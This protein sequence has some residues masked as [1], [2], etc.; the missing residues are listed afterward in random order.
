M[1]ANRNRCGKCEQE[2]KRGKKNLSKRAKSK[3]R[4]LT[5]QTAFGMTDWVLS[6]TTDTRLPVLENDLV[7]H[8]VIFGLF[9]VHDV[10]T[11]YILFDAFDGLTG[12]LRENAV[13][14]GAHAENFFGVKIDVGS[15]SAEAAHPRLVN[16]D[17]G[18]R[19]GEPFF[20]SAAGE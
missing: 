10:V 1:I 7:D 8:A 18:I 3:E 20:G 17:P 19:Q 6:V 2:R 16:Q 12:M 4:F 13:D 9:R 15:L 14:G 11:F 5:S